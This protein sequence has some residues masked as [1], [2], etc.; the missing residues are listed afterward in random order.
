MVQG[1]GLFPHLTIEDNISIAGKLAFPKVHSNERINHLMDLVGLPL[2]LK[3]KYPFQ[4]SGGE[5]QRTGVCRAL[6]L[7]PPL[8]LMDEPFGALDPI[9][10]EDIQKE[11]LTV[12]KN[13]PRTI[14]LVTHDMREAKKLADNILVIDEG[15][16]QQFDR[17]SQVL[18]QPANEIVKRLINASLA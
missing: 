16:V 18:A 7:N 13:E 3:N 15:E 6:F 8:L 4:L 2:S 10:R 17:A 12:Q 11:I 14:L 9:T 1:T 5:Q